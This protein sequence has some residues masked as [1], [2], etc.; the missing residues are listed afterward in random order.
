ML[1][2]ILGAYYAPNNPQFIMG[3]NYSFIAFELQFFKGAPLLELGDKKEYFM[4]KCR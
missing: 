2:Y 3:E 4:R 1:Y